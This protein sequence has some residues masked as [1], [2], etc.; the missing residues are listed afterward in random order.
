MSTLYRN[1]V[2]LT[3]DPGAAGPVDAF[4]VTNGRFAAVGDRALDA[5]GRSEVVDL[6]GRTVV[7]GL[8]DAHA[9]LE[10]D[11]LS[12]ACWVDVRDVPLD[13][14]LERL[15][16]HASA[17]PPGEWVVGQATFGQD[18]DMPGRA[19]LDAAL[20]DH[21]VIV[22]ASMH[23]MSANTRALERAGLLSRQHVP[24]PTVIY[25][26][27]DG[28]PTGQLLEAH[29]LFPVAVITRGPHRDH[30]GRDQGTVQPLRR[31]HRVRG[32]HVPPGHAG[33]PAP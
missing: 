32:P 9:H 13:V 27:A 2:V 6:G 33:L 5:A 30:R 29:H 20:P 28:E 7:P 25:R 23:A 16:G 14:M 8:I 19:V 17:L 26:D 31:H 21:P 24:A 12:H 1:G 4:L 3:M 11:A 10:T 22:R 18:R 15:R